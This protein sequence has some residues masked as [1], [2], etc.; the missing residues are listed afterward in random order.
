VSPFAK[1]RVASV[2]P[3]VFE[4]AAAGDALAERIVQGA[5]EEL[6]RGAE[7]L[8]RQL[9]PPGGAG[10]RLEQVVLAGGVL[11]H[12]AGLREALAGRLRR[13]APGACCVV[14]EVEGAAGAARVARRW[15][16][17]GGRGAR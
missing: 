1:D 14:P 4:A 15:H 2:A 13:L 3:V 16:E 6:G 8:A 10:E 12:Q 5:A 9:W 11:L 7:A 17:E